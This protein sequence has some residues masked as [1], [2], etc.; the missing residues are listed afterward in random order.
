MTNEFTVE[1]RKPDG[2]VDGYRVWVGTDDSYT[3]L[4]PDQTSYRVMNLDPATQY[5][6]RIATVVGDIESEKSSLDVTTST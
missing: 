1:W 4:Q 5:T 6:V 3:T 2:G